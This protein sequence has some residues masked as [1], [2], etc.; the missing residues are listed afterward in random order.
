MNA[1]GTIGTLAESEEVGITW[2]GS[3]EVGIAWPGSE[4]VGI[5]WLRVKRLV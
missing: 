1:A 3:E 5:I 2:P 4:E